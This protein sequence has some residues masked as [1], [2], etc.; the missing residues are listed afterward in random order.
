VE[1]V[2]SENVIAKYLVMMILVVSGV[3]HLSI[4]GILNYE[5]EIPQFMYLL[6]T[7]I[8][9]FLLSIICTKIV[10][11]NKRIK[12]DANIWRNSVVGN[13]FA[14]ILL[15]FVTDIELFIVFFVFFA[16]AFTPAT[17]YFVIK[18][19]KHMN[20]PTINK[21]CSSRKEN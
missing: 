9:I 19:K 12:Y 18:C 3:F 21:K 1:V 11:G 13:L 20:R 16:V 15:S 14:I 4:I 5:I 8:F 7:T 6:L 2:S 17:A 10:I